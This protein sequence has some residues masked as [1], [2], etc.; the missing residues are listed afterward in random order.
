M[1]F[2]MVG[3]HRQT[4]MRE[5]VP[6]ECGVPLQVANAPAGVGL[7][8]GERGRH[9]VR[10]APF[11]D[12]V[13]LFFG[14]ELGRIGRQPGRGKIAGMR[15]EKGLDLARRMGRAAIPDDQQG[16][17]KDAPKVPQRPTRGGPFDTAADM[18]RR[19]AARGGHRDHAGDLPAFAQA[20]QQRGP[21]PQGPG[22]RYAGPKRVTRFV[23]AGNRPPFA[24]SF[25]FSAGQSRV[26]H[27]RTTAS[28]RSFACTAGRWGVKPCALSGRSRYR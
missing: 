17:P 15:S 23:H 10:H 5:E 19:E 2:T 6:H 14:I 3:R 26:S 24:T 12:G 13:G 18:P 1:T 4:G 28:S 7:E 8:L 27:A 16:T 11:D 21:A 25:F 20:A 22:R 9:R